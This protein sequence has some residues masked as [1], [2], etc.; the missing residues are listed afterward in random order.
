MASQ[1]A[2]ASKLESMYNRARVLNTTHNKSISEYVDLPHPSPISY[3]LEVNF[4]SSGKTVHVSALKIRHGKHAGQKI[5]QH[6][7]ASMDLAS[8]KVSV[9]SGAAP[10]L[11]DVLTAVLTHR[12]GGKRASLRNNSN[13]NRNNTSPTNSNFSNFGSSNN[14]EVFPSNRNTVTRAVQ[15]WENNTLYA[16]IGKHRR[17]YRNTT[18]NRNTRTINHA[19]GTY[20]SNFALR[21]PAVPR[22]IRLNPSKTL[23]RGTLLPIREFKD[24]KDSA[25][26]TDENYLT[27]SLSKDEAEEF[28][29]ALGNY[30]KGKNVQVLFELPLSAIRRKTPWLWMGN[31]NNNVVSSIVHQTVLPPGTMEIASLRRSTD[32]AS[33][34]V[35]KVASYVPDTGAT[36]LVGE[37]RIAPSPSPSPNRSASSPNATS[38][39]S[40]SASRSATQKRSPSA[41]PKSRSATQKPSAPKKRSLSPNRASPSP[42]RRNPR[43]SAT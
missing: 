25:T 16:A 15:N 42:K 30:K 36:T 7:Y 34:W 43:R 37:K 10:R 9:D 29:W 13:S 20:L 28:I 5:L 3:L 38:K 11:R 14:N 40:P 23:Y 39:R 32:D 8:G 33:I 2:L 1:K 24:M 26:L 27:F 21:S 4:Y 12:A 41:A 18:P 22:S 35:A 6:A 31:K 19:M 17:G